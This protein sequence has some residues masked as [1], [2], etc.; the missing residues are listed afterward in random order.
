MKVMMA[1]LFFDSFLIIL[2][3]TLLNNS[4][5][6]A[7][8]LK[9]IKSS[10]I[11][12]VNNSF[13]KT[14]RYLEKDYGRFFPF[15]P[16]IAD[17]KSSINKLDAAHLQHPLECVR[18][19]YFN[20]SSRDSREK[21]D[22]GDFKKCTTDI[23][24][25]KR[26]PPP[27][28]FDDPRVYSLF[29]N[30]DAQLFSGWM[31]IAPNGTTQID[32][33]APLSVRKKP[34]LECL[35]FSRE[36]QDSP[37]HFSPLLRNHKASSANLFISAFSS[38]YVLYAGCLQRAL[39][40]FGITAQRNPSAVACC[41]HYR[42]PTV[43]G[44]ITNDE[45]KDY[46]LRNK[47][48]MPFCDQNKGLIIL[49]CRFNCLKMVPFPPP[50]PLELQ[51][52]EIK[53][54]KDA[55]LDS[56]EEEKDSKRF[57]P[58]NEDD[59][60]FEDQLAAE[61]LARINAALKPSDDSS[62]ESVPSTSA[63]AYDA[64]EPR[65]STSA[66]AYGAQNPQPSTSAQAYGSQTN[67]SGGMNSNS[68][69]AAK[70]QEE[71][72]DSSDDDDLPCGLTAVG[73][74]DEEYEEAHFN[75]THYQHSL[76]SRP[77]SA[78]KYKKPDKNDDDQKKKT[79]QEKQR[80]RIH[81][82]TFRPIFD[83]KLRKQIQTVLNDAEMPQKVPVQPSDLTDLLISAIE[84]GFL[85]PDSG[86]Q[87]SM[88]CD[89]KERMS[90]HS[91]NFLVESSRYRCNEQRLVGNNDFVKAPMGNVEQIW[92]MAAFDV[93]LLVD[94]GDFGRPAIESLPIIHPRKKNI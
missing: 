62:Q 23:F 6:T 92:M 47:K 45:I 94:N 44:D 89:T 32:M 29:H 72:T 57:R 74:D 68:I 59:E 64:Q 9:N 86:L 58:D 40:P 49:I 16:S 65:P 46:E 27:R 15:P 69:S 77:N 88:D 14:G 35:G 90:I 11:M 80:H 73:S 78:D 20:E 4:T 83:E 8:K 7:I 21:G 56:S 5:S 42:H 31:Q 19:I 50:A 84:F 81:I 87:M 67:A 43:V 22:L 1:R 3:A 39:E 28:Q 12:I 63:Q 24:F 79:V 2:L 25:G 75:S 38:D 60:A 54:T 10:A 17:E 51:L 70:S 41:E 33:P 18:E 61:M 91:A 13:K 30:T 71:D 85:A 34:A 55:S 36:L 37:V 26:L 53:T 76:W 93:K 48:Q 52:P 66:Q 82:F